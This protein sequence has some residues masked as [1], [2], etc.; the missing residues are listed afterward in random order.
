MAEHRGYITQ[1]KIQHPVGAHFNEP[2][3]PG[4][5]VAYLVPIAIERVLPKGNDILIKKRE[6]YWINQYHSTRFGANIR[7]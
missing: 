6:S 2:G 4:D 3:H 5:P 1:K 7:D